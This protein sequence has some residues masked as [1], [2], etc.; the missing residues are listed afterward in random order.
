LQKLNEW[1]KKN[2]IN[3]ALCQLAEKAIINDCP[4]LVKSQ[5]DSPSLFIDM[6]FNQIIKIFYSAEASNSKIN[7]S[8]YEALSECKN[9]T[10]IILQFALCEYDIY[11]EFNQIIIALASCLISSKEKEDDKNIYQ[12][13]I[14]LINNLNI[15]FGL[16]E[17]CM[18]KIINNFNSD[19]DDYSDENTNDEEFPKISP[20]YNINS[21]GDINNFENKEKN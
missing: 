3:I 14:T 6:I 1:I 10:Y 7:N 16:I 4:N 20:K 17:K 2:D 18:N 9:N 21:L 12:N 8:L 5:L 11:S 15:E 19:E 13:I